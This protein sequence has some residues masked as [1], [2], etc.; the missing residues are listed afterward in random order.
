MVSLPSYPFPIAETGIDGKGL[1]I[2]TVHRVSLDTA[3]TAGVQ[4]RTALANLYYRPLPRISPLPT[5]VSPA[6]WIGQYKASYTGLTAAL[7]ANVHLLTAHSLGPKTLLLR[8]AHSYETGEDSTNSQPATVN[9]ATIFAPFTITAATE[10]T[11]TGNQPLTAAP[12]VTY[13]VKNPSGGAPTTVT[14]PVVPPA[15]SGNGLQITLSPMQIRTFM[16]T[17]S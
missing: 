12:Q 15:P 14:L 5:G 10:M 11:L 3:A 2:R 4:R 9:L 7:P 8:V 6:Q 16:C 1:I 13:Q 17:T